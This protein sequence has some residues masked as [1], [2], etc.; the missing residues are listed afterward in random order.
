M[1]ARQ[2]AARRDEFD[3]LWESLLG[4]T[5]SQQNRVLI[6]N[7]PDAVELPAVQ[8]MLCEDGGRLPITAERWESVAE[9]VLNEAAEFTNRVKDDCLIL[10]KSI[11]LDEWCSSDELDWTLLDT[12]AALFT[13][14]GNLYSFAALFQCFTRSRRW[15][16]IVPHISYNPLVS[17]VTNLVI[18]ALDL[19]GD[20]TVDSLKVFDGRLMCLCGNP[21]LGAP[22]NFSCL[23]SPGWTHYLSQI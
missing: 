9:I 5:E 14:K 20:T 13:Y 1:E 17:R 12:P 16:S 22:M 2:V 18:K 19:P 7:L 3:Q 11:E 23:V 6:P 8:A 15:S 10:M 21:A 4:S